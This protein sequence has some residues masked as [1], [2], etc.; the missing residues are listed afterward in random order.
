MKP[1]IFT[2]QE[3]APFPWCPLKAYMI[4]LR[5]ARILLKLALFLRAGKRLQLAFQPHITPRE[6]RF[7][8]GRGGQRRQECFTL[9]QRQTSTSQK[10]LCK[11]FYV[12]EL[13]QR[14]LFVIAQYELLKLHTIHLHLWTKMNV[15]TFSC[16]RIKPINCS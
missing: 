14:N 1:V 7:L 15:V 16:F 4:W 10:Q 11:L 5:I 8:V 9:E 2:G 3:Q 13:I 12:F 6:K